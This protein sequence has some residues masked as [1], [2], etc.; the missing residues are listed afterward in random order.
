M[1]GLELIMVLW[2]FK[3]VLPVKLRMLDEVI[4]VV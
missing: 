1:V 3:M 4:W 2:E